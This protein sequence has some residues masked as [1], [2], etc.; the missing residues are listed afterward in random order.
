[1][2]S[3]PVTYPHI[4]QIVLCGQVAHDAGR[5]R[6][7]DLLAIIVIQ[8]WISKKWHLPKSSNIFVPIRQTRHEFKTTNGGPCQPVDLLFRVEVH[9]TATRWTG[10]VS[11][12]LYEQVG[13][14][15]T[16]HTVSQ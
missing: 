14:D 16:H 1:M 6:K 4:I 10:V 3:I 12:R 8:I 15:L 13:D 9:H 5:L 7:V 11:T 2:A